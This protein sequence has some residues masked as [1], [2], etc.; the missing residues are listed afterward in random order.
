VRAYD[1]GCKVTKCPIAIMIEGMPGRL[2]R[3]TR[4]YV[5][6]YMAALL[7][8]YN[9]LLGPLQLSGQVRVFL[10]LILPL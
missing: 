5:W 7:G 6:R 8:P 9:F 4:S 10:V 1:A 3:K 2:D